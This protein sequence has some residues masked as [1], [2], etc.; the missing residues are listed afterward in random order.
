MHNIE[1]IQTL[2]IKS[3]TQAPPNLSCLW[4]CLGRVMPFLLVS[5]FFLEVEYERSSLNPLYNFIE[6][7]FCFLVCLVCEMHSLLVMLGATLA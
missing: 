6:E 4:S 1:V 3:D 7:F 2:C 5:L